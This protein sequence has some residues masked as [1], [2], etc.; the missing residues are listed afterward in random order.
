MSK[1]CLR[2]GKQQGDTL[3]LQE[4]Y[5]LV[6]FIEKEVKDAHIGLETVFLLVNLVIA[7][8]L[9]F[10]VRKGFLGANRIAEILD[11]SVEC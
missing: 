4:E 5:R 7:L 6:A 3:L 8:R 9:E 2:E 11:W 10:G 1:F